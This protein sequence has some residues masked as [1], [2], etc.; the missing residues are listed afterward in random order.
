MLGHECTGVSTILELATSVASIDFMTCRRSRLSYSSG[1]G[2]LTHDIVRTK[3]DKRKRIE[4][5]GA[6]NDNYLIVAAVATVL[7]SIAGGRVHSSLRQRMVINRQGIR[8][9]GY[10]HIRYGRLDAAN[11]RANRQRGPADTKLR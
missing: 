1:A 3:P 4:P 11:N 6:V 8:L 5:A 10:W 2:P 9:S 7:P